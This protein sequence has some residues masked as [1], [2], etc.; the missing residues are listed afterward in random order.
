M[1]FLPKIA[2]AS[3]LA[4]QAGGKEL[5]R[6]AQSAVW[7]S[8]VYFAL[9]CD[10][11]NLPPRRSAA[12]PLS[13][14]GRESATFNG[15]ND[16]LTCALVGDR[17]QVLLRRLWSDA[18]IRELYVGDGP[19]GQPAYCQWL[20]RARDQW[21]LQEYSPG[22]YPALKDDEVMVE[23][24]Y[25]FTAYR[26]KGAMADGM[27]Q[28]LSIARSEGARAALTYVGEENVASLRGCAAVGFRPQHLTRSVRRLGVHQSYLLPISDAS[29][30]RWD[31]ATT[32]G[33]GARASG[34]G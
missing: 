29:Q 27:H 5:A 2:A 24:A 32:S 8:H 34:S 25:T 12:I 28:L 18:G 10:L 1:G 6:Q 16:E 33:G 19:D 31:A 21:P 15:F 22:R 9:W 3:A 23:G 7:F 11:E 20:V 30:S 14:T 26:R 17:S 4:R 13:M